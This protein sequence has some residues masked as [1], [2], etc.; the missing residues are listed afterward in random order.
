MRKLRKIMIIFAAVIVLLAV[1]V[2]LFMQTAPFGKNP[3]GKRL[4]QIEKSP[5][6]RE[7][8]F[9]NLSPTIMMAENASYMKMIVEYFSAGV[10]REPENPLPSVKRN[11]KV[12]PE[13]KPTITWFGHSSY[14]IQAGGK[15]ILIDPVFSERTSPVSFAGS[16]SYA[17]TQ[18]YNVEDFPE[19]DLIILTHDHYDHLDYNTIL[20]FKDKAAKFI[21]PLGVG[22]HLESWGFDTSR[23][24]EADWWEEIRLDDSLKIAV[25]PARHFSGRGFVRNKTLWASFVLM[26]P[27]N[28]IYVGGDSG[29]DRH[30]REIG[31]K[32]GPFDI[33]MLESGQYN[34]KWPQIHMMPEQT[35]QASVDLKAAVLMPVHWGKFTLALH[36]WNEPV[37]R[38][39][40]RA[41]ELKVKVTTPMLGERLVIGERLPEKKWWR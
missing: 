4:E 25:T 28:R 37:E 26:F 8:S 34:E 27:D 15:N 6:Y 29:Y 41:E 9:L 21:M 3:S 33:A 30:F 39:L 13:N 19:I 20:K 36:P 14:F 32:Y 1:A 23:I 2:F 38:V 35:V 5:N 12:A 31:D 10:N 22:S 40:A 24:M 7:G 18:V 16:K 11:L 17:G